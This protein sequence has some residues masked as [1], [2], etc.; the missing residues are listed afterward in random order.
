[1]FVMQ[2]KLLVIHFASSFFQAL[3]VKMKAGQQTSTCPYSAGCPPSDW[4]QGGIYNNKYCLPAPVWTSTEDTRPADGVNNY[5]WCFQQC[6]A[7]SS[8]AGVTY[9]NGGNQWCYFCNVGSSFKLASAD[10]VVAQVGSGFN[11]A[12]K[13]CGANK[14]RSQNTSQCTQCT[15]CQAGRFERQACASAKDTDCGECSKLHK[16][17]GGTCGQCTEFEC[18]AWTCE[19]GY[20]HRPGSGCK[21]CS[22]CGTGTFQHQPCGT[23]SDTACVDCSSKHEIIG[24]QCTSCTADACTGFICG[25]GYDL[26]GDG[27]SCLPTNPTSCS[28]RFPIPSGDCRSCSGTAC[29]GVNCSAG[30]YVNSANLCASCALHPIVSGTCKSCDAS[31]CS[32]VECHAGFYANGATCRPCSTCTV[33]QDRSSWPYTYSSLEY[34]QTSCSQKSDAV[35]AEYESAQLTQDWYSGNGLSQPTGAAYRNKYGFKCYSTAQSITVASVTACQAAVGSNAFS[36]YKG[37]CLDC[38]WTYKCYDYPTPAEGWTYYQGAVPYT[39][40][41]CT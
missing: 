28:A 41:A 26:S 18:T 38:G 32:E 17:T 30:Y 4:V 5:A 36:Y 11:I 3:G 25:S 10:N 24:G 8:C 27:S 23:T 21:E 14:Y 40:L 29:T 37:E 2:Q 16:E 12:F 1:M 33:D 20:F 7:N 15:S 6:G 19:S 13:A 34:T 35:C 31:S 9:K 22:L 39:G